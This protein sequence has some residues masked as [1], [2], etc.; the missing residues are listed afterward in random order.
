MSLTIKTGVSTWLW[1]SPIHTG[2]VD[3]IFR[4]IS[5]FGFQA[6][7]IAVEDPAI[8]DKDAVKE[9]LERYNLIPVV[10]AAFGPSRDL[11]HEDPAIHRQCFE[12]IEEC[13]RCAAAWGAGFVAGPM[14]S[15]VGKT[16]MLPPEKRAAEWK[17]AVQNLRIASEMAASYNC[18]LA[19]EPLNRFESDLVNTAN[20]VARLI[21]DINH[22]AA[23][24]M[25]DSFHMSIEE[26]DPYQA[27]ITAGKDLIHMQISENHRGIPGTGI[28]PWSKYKDALAEIGY[29]EVVSIESF[30]PQNQ[31]LAG[32]VC[33][34]HPFAESQDEFA[35]QGLQFMSD[36]FKEN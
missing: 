14:Y 24:I 27:I 26:S 18:Q 35:Q 21:R 10:C 17:L 15:A 22:P 7:E 16:R 33:I 31:E 9:A 8:L 19:L 20:D 29:K 6:V 28:T 13:L 32:A 25:L 36:L 2:N 11:T 1:T 5:E 12:Y 23:K 4:K 34:W 30:T 3:E